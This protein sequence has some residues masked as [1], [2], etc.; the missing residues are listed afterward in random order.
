M[1]PEW[2]TNWTGKH[3]EDFNS[4]FCEPTQCG[5]CVN[6]SCG[7]TATPEGKPLLRCGSCGIAT[8]CSVKC[9]EASWK[10]EHSAECRAMVDPHSSKEI[11]A[12]LDARVKIMVKH[13][14]E[15]AMFNDLRLRMH[16][17]GQEQVS[18][19][20]AASIREAG[21][22]Q[23]AAFAE[24]RASVEALVARQPLQQLHVPPSLYQ[25]D[26][27]DRQ[28]QHSLQPERQKQHSLL[29]PNVFISNV[30]ISMCVVVLSIFLM[31]C[32]AA[33]TSAKN[34]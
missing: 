27:P 31:Y 21:Q 30:F 23:E 33:L 6:E 29:S 19:E 9:Q 22:R 10:A 15:A 14:A 13:D 25:I 34:T 2:L 20:L 18:A 26:E 4:R 28:K 12:K 3:E 11:G 17:F 7:A 24:A 5:S 32:I 1:P 8:F 16:Y